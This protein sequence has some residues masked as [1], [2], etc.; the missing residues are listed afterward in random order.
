LFEEVFDQSHPIEGIKKPVDPRL[1]DNY[2]IDHVFKMAQLGKVCTN[3]EP[4]QPPNMSSATA[5]C[6]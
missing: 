5:A 1:R 2:P 4:Q 6:F 3:S